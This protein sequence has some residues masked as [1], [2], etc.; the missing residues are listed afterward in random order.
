[1]PKIAAFLINLDD[2]HD[3]LDHASKA[4]TTVA[5][6]FERVSAYDGRGKPPEHVTAYDRTRAIRL[7]GRPLTGGEVGCYMSHL[8]CAERFLQTDAQFGLVMEDDLA[9]T[10]DTA[11]A[12]PQL[13]EWLHA[14]GPTTWDLV[15]LCREPRRFFAPLTNVGS[16]TLCHAFYFPTTT[17]ALLWSRAGAARFL[18]T[19]AEIF[20]PVDHFLRRWCSK[21]GRG[22][23]CKPA[24][25]TTSGAPSDIDGEAGA[26]PARRR[27]AKSPAY[28]VREFRRQSANYLNAGRNLRRYR[29]T[30]QPSPQE[31]MQTQ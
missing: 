30:A 2:N 14:K 27:F 31:G 5:I 18:E 15:N 6:P 7:Y 10:P 22:L 29:L 25:F 17:T 13:A 9:I 1:M 3:R 26:S 20:M 28:F 12:F 21:S 16:C 23:A 19:R 8:N 24:I 4:L 11:K